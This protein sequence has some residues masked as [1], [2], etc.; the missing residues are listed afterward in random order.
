MEKGENKKAEVVN[1]M[2][3][4]FKAI[5]DMKI[6]SFS[7]FHTEEV[8]NMDVTLK[9]GNMISLN[10]KH[11][12]GKIEDV[13]RE[14][15]IDPDAVKQIK[16]K[17]HRS[18]INS[19]SDIVNTYNIDPNKLYVD[20][21]IAWLTA[22]TDLN[23]V[24]MG[25]IVIPVYDKKSKKLSFAFFDPINNSK[26]PVV[27]NYFK[28]LKSEP[29]TES[30]S[31]RNGI[32]RAVVWVDKQPYTILNDKVFKVP[33][34][35]K[36]NFFSLEVDKNVNYLLYEDKRGVKVMDYKEHTI[37]HVP[38][39]ADVINYPIMFSNKIAVLSPRNAFGD[40]SHY[41]LLSNL[42]TKNPK[43]EKL[44]EKNT[45]TVTELGIDKLAV[46]FD[47]KD[48]SIEF[49]LYDKDA[50]QPLKYTISKA[51]VDKYKL[52]SKGFVI[53]KKNN[54]VFLGE[55]K[56]TFVLTVHP[57]KLSL[58]GVFNNPEPD[59]NKKEVFTDYDE[60]Y[61]DSSIAIVPAEL[62][63]VYRHTDKCIIYV[64][65]KGRGNY[66]LVNKIPVSKMGVNSMKPY[67]LVGHDN[68]YI[69]YKAGKKF[70]G[71]D[72]TGKKPIT[73]A[74]NLQVVPYY[75]YYF[76]REDNGKSQNRVIDYNEA[77]S[78]LYYL[79]MGDQ[80]VHENVIH[81]NGTIY[82][83]NKMVV[84][85]FV[86]HPQKVVESPMAS[87]T[88]PKEEVCFVRYGNKPRVMYHTEGEEAIPLC[89]LTIEG[90][91]L[92]LFLIDHSNTHYMQDKTIVHWLLTTPS[93][94]RV[95]ENAVAL[96]DKNGKPYV[97]N[98]YILGNEVGQQVESLFKELE[99]NIQAK[100]KE[101][102]K[103]LEKER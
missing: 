11:E 16:L 23:K 83:N 37:L 81:L 33:V 34:A 79:N 102:D 46:V 1:V 55:R 41:L 17:A 60:S 20:S 85:T 32:F 47:K 43:V 26:L 25:S 72:R 36:G 97:H 76:I 29:R 66:E 49:R 65:K 51:V 28:N 39:T 62:Y 38:V 77:H 89:N 80:S 69:Y 87:T 22:V 91:D 61:V 88:E 93:G 67:Y 101:Q 40:E 50:S 12:E 92:C 24:K 42:D 70:I 73:I 27:V 30:Y 63:S 45:M 96:V 52:D 95:A 53:E 19:D 57:G 82:A 4:P 13:L 21:D 78:S 31:F 5:R 99:S 90:K 59:Q 103:G 18:G 68:D 9:N 54:I 7:S 75:R 74:D 6:G 14:H 44:P 2:R 15:E 56:N 98:P 35:E 8:V 64:F 100:S 10:H 94:E 48:G 71:I 84:G 86:K 3:V 58:K